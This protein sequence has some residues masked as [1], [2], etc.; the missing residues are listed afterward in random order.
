MYVD[1]KR[2]ESIIAMETKFVTVIVTGE[3]VQRLAAEVLQQRAARAVLQDENELLRADLG[4]PTDIEAICERLA[5]V[6][7]RLAKG[8]PMIGRDITELREQ[9]AGV[10]AFNGRLSERLD[11]FGKELHGVNIGETEHHSWVRGQL[12]AQSRLSRQRDEAA[13]QRINEIVETIGNRIAQLDEMLD[14][15]KHGDLFELRQRFDEFETRSINLFNRHSTDIASLE[16]PDGEKQDG[17]AFPTGGA[18]TVASTEAYETHFDG[19]PV[20]A[21]QLVPR[22]GDRV[23]LEGALTTHGAPVADGWYDVIGHEP[24]VPVFQIHVGTEAIE[25]GW[26]P[27]LYAS[28]T[29]LKEVRRATA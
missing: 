5:K 8:G 24:A 23:R 25:G 11:A 27:W 2:V 7:D 28:Q 26:L 15:L 17:A 13:H 14:V 10:A 19:E 12:D 20:P 18:E 9:V 21:E 6:E 16:F 1:Q 22:R 3:E 29:G 4:K